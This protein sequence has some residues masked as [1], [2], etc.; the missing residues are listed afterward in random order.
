MGRTCKFQNKNW[1]SLLVIPERWG[2]KGSFIYNM[3]IH[4]LLLD[5]LHKQYLCILTF[6]GMLWRFEPPDGACGLGWVV[7][8]PFVLPVFHSFI[9]SV[10]LCCFIV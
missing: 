8:F 2:S 4:L 3:C 6:P 7:I 5:Q 10:L 9:H 1:S